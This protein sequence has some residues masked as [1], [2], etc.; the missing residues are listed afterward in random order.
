MLQSYKRKEME[1]EAFNNQM[2]TRVPSLPTETKPELP[3]GLHSLERAAICP[4]HNASAS[5][6]MCEFLKCHVYHDDLPHSICSDQ[7]LSLQ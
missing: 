3:L 7:E 5:T 6:P 2:E 1:E 4:P